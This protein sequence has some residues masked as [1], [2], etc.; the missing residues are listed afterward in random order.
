M[1]KKIRILAQEINK[2]CLFEEVKNVSTLSEKKPPLIGLRN[3]GKKVGIVWLF[4]DL[5][6]T[7][8]FLRVASIEQLSLTEFNGE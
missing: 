6:Y 8:M 3:R 5:R 4:R 1:K 2:V 7:T